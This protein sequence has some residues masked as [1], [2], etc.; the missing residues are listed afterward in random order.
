MKILDPFC[1]Y[2]GD[3]TLFYAVTTELMIRK[4]LDENG[5]NQ[6]DFSAHIDMTAPL[7]G[8]CGIYPTNNVGEAIKFVAGALTYIGCRVKWQDSPQEEGGIRIAVRLPKNVCIMTNTKRRLEHRLTEGPFAD[9]Y[10]VVLKRNTVFYFSEELFEDDW[11]S[12]VNIVQGIIKLCKGDLDYG[13]M[14]RVA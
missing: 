2:P 4:L 14:D 6:Q 11:R 7:N 8:K 5:Y 3:F 9:Y 10:V 1:F 12:L 13:N